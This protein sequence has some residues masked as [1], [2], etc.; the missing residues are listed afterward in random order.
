MTDRQTDRQNNCIDLFKLIMAIAV[1]AIHTHPLENCTSG[2]LLK[3]YEIMVNMAVP[4]FFLASGYFLGMKMDWPY[5]ENVNDINRIIK[6]LKRIIQMYLIW[7]A[8]YLP[9][10]IYH[11]ISLKTIPIKAAL[12]YIRGFIFI[13]EQYNSWPLWY[14]LSTIYALLII[15]LLF[16]LKKATEINLILLSV[17]ASIVSIGLTEFV[18]YEGDLSFTLQN[19]QKLVVY[20]ISSGRIFRG[21]IY[22]PI[23]ILLTNKKVS[24]AVSSLVLIIGFVV[25]FFTNNNIISSYLLIIISIAFF[26]L[27]KSVKLEYRKIY[28]KLRSL[29]TTIYLVH[30]YVWTFYYKIVYGE[31]TYGLDSFL[32]TLIISILVC[33]AINLKPKIKDKR[34]K[35][36]SSIRL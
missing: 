6:Q 1:V 29:S 7:T 28:P 21:M 32:A 10:A 30:M 13:G 2:D 16:K 36:F 22:I 23:G 11:F 4:F 35:I 33:L 19:I 34:N 5:S 14:L 31:K 26:E 8:I 18:I 9:L 15:Y 24:S 12:I 20:S 27:V 3:I 25:A 17:I